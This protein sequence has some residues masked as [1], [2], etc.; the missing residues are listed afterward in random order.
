MMPLE[1]NPAPE[2]SEPERDFLERL[3]ALALDQD[4]CPGDFTPDAIQKIANSSTSLPRGP[5]LL[6][7][8][9]EVS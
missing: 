4:A 9:T 1:E 8:E 6:S 7:D 2:A 5:F 3:Q